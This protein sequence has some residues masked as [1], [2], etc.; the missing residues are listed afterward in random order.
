MLTALLLSLAALLPDPP[1]VNLTADHTKIAQSCIV[2][3]APGT[4]IADQD[5]AGVIEIDADN[6]TLDFE[7]GSL[8]KG[9]ATGTGP[10]QI[11]WDQLTGCAIRI[12]NHE[13]ITLKN[14]SIS[15]Y[16]VGVHATTA[17]GLKIETADIH[18]GFRQHLKST[19]QAEDQADWLWPHANDAH[20]WVT[21]Y[22][23]AVCVEDSSNITIHDLAVRRSQNG[24]IL[25]RVSHA[26]IYD[27][28]CSFLSG[29]GVAMWR[30]CDNTIA[31]NALD[32]CVRG[33]SE[34][35]YN[36]G[37][38]SAGIL[39]FEQCSRNTFNEN[40]VT[41]SGDGFFGFA[42][43]EAI[44]EI[45]SKD[46]HF[47]YAKAGC[48]DNIITNN[49]F[50]YSPAHGLELTF[51]RS[52]K[53][54]SNRFEEN[55]ICGIW[56][57][58][59]THTLIEGNTFEGNGGMSYGQERGGIN[60]EHGSYNQILRNTFTNNRCAVH[61]WWDDD[62]RLLEMPGVKANGAGE[63]TNNVIARN[64]IKIDAN[65]PFKGPNDTGPLVGLQ[66]RDTGT[67]HLKQNV[68]AGNTV[69]IT[70]TRGRELDIAPGC[71][72][73]TDETGF[74]TGDAHPRSSI[75]T[76]TPIGARDNLKGRATILMD[77][78]G[79]WDH[80][81]PFVRRTPTKDGDTYEV[82]G[83]KDVEYH[84]MSGG[85]KISVEDTVPP[86]A[87]K[88]TVSAISDVVRYSVDLKVDGQTQSLT[89]TLMDCKWDILAFP[90]TKDPRDDHAG[91]L[92][93]GQAA[94]IPLTWTNH[95]D[96]P[97]AHG[98]PQAI[99]E[100]SEFK[101]KLPGQN[102]FGLIA[103]TLVRI[104]KGKWRITTMSD[105]GIQVEVI[106]YKRRDAP[107]KTIINNWTWHA[108]T[109]D[110]GE[111]EMEKEEAEAVQIRIEYFQLDGHAALS[112]DLTPE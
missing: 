49:D 50:S 39:C 51:S 72:P 31:R 17:D 79:P 21:N 13:N 66:L 30:S 94:G 98:G 96:L 101:D 110:S 45:P 1:T 28:D 8:L 87:A 93:D 90:W 38:D 32:F 85:T 76:K 60:I 40:S 48:N 105:D 61:L 24:I 12:N 9:A 78:W 97:L 83:A 109:K 2:H 65:H 89:G 22:G 14:L 63:V 53:I 41:H 42:G 3:I 86:D 64:T 18:D 107:R 70:Q 19:P 71:E 80:T 6:I 100:W 103:S 10:N 54:L 58:Y 47:D 20:E 26:S 56:G 67:G 92:A 16:K 35:V 111:F 57:G 74:P 37:Q 75:G 15:G 4:V 43:K 77:D 46:P 81:S 33:H 11:P 104:P 102:H 62:G 44:G 91:W 112:L 69:T 59:S 36:R 88:F 99:K 73:I 95:L 27:N 23:A 7:Q 25:D 68:Y 29:W 84:A 55:A 52:N 108:P 34:G 5:G 106:W 82:L